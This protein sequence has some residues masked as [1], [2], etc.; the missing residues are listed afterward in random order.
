M[1][2]RFNFLSH[3]VRYFVSIFWPDFLFLISFQNLMRSRWCYK[4]GEYSRRP[5][6]N[7]LHF[8]SDW[9]RHLTRSVSILLNSLICVGVMSEWMELIREWSACG[10]EC[11]SK[12]L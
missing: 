9:R 10:S 11:L 2:L 7:F 12:S 8:V 5:V 3:R 6:F 4:I 1:S